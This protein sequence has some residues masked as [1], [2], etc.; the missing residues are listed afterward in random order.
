MVAGS[1]PAL[2]D[3]EKLAV[4]PAEF[5]VTLQVPGVGS[6]PVIYAMPEPSTVIFP[7][8]LKLMVILVAS[9]LKVFPSQSN[10]HKSNG[11]VVTLGYRKPK[12]VNVTLVPAA[13]EP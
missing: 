2:A 8:L 11:V 3:E 1:G 12:G 6:Y 13:T 4:V 9:R 10:V 7:L 5:P